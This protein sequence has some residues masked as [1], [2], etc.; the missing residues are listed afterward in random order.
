MYCL[1]MV[2]NFVKVW[3]MLMLSLRCGLFL[4]QGRRYL[5]HFQASAA[6]DR[7]LRTLA[8]ILFNLYNC[9]QGTSHAAQHDL[10]EFAEHVHVVAHGTPHSKDAI[11][12]LDTHHIDV[13]GISC[14]AHR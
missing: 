12:K 2:Q 11:G 10:A 9:W 6:P 14:L 5:Q 7:G 13:H 1:L 8:I 4:T 3:N